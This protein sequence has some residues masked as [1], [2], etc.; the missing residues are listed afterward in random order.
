MHTIEPFAYWQ[1]YYQAHLDE[2]S[3]YFEQ[4]NN[5]NYS[6]TIYNYYISPL[7]DD[8]GSETLFGKILFVDYENASMVLELMG[9]WNDALHNDIMFL[10]RN[11]IDHFLGEGIQKFI[12]IGE[13]VLNF[14][15]DEGDYYEEWLE[16]VEDGWIVAIG[17]HEHVYAEWNK[18]P[19]SYCFHYGESLELTKWRTLPPALFCKHI[20]H[21][22]QHRL[23]L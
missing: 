12:L 15:S 2:R 17:F 14:H 19:I 23:P 10:K 7:W 22:I 6:T 1:S 11:I 13:N 21:T 8:I 16:E 18:G 5:S 4:E 20:T 9:E 3:P